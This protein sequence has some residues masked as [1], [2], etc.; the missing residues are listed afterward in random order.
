MRDIEEGGREPALMSISG[1]WEKRRIETFEHLG[2]IGSQAFA[3][4]I[5]N[6]AGELILGLFPLLE[7]P[8]GAPRFSDYP[9]SLGVAS[10]DPLPDGVVLWTRLAPEPL[11]HLLRDRQVGDQVTVDVPDLTPP[12]AKRYG[13]KPARTRTSPRPAEN[14]PLHQRQKIIVHSGSPLLST[15]LLADMMN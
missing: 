11:A 5:S 10:G 14:I 4:S 15:A 7:R 6:K 8:I 12:V 9:F 3:R 13:A 2:S 1:N